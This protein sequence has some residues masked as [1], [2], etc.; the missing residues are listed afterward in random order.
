MSM[1]RGG[2]AMAVLIGGAL[3]IL[4][5]IPHAL[6]PARAA[7]AEIGGPVHRARAALLSTLMTG[8]LGALTLPTAECSNDTSGARTVVEDLAFHLTALVGGGQ[9]GA[10]CEP[11]APG[12]EACRVVV[13]QS[14][15]G[16]EIR[17]SRFY[18]F[19][20]STDGRV[21]DRTLV[22]LTVP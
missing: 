18:H 10:S 5:T 13:G 2:R 1:P 19:T 15:P 11:S 3:A 12:Q 8:P 7:D 6:P 14:I 16:T 17:W 21:D 4:C 20:R 22:C 9:V